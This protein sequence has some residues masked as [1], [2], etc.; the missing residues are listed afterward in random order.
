MNFLVKAR[1]RPAANDRA[2]NVNKRTFDKLAAIIPYTTR[3][4]ILHQLVP[5]LVKCCIK[6]HVQSI[7]SKD[8]FFEHLSVITSLENYKK[9]TRHF[10]LAL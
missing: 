8:N 2:K 7:G 10:S 3:L 6:G 1:A 4:S 5:S 9:D